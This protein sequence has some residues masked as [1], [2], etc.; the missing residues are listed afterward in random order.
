MIFGALA[1][2]VIGTDGT[3]TNM[4][5]LPPSSK[6]L[7][8]CFLKAM[9]SYS[10][11]SV[12]PTMRKDM[13]APQDLPN[14]VFKAMVL[15][16]VTYMF[17]PDICMFAFGMPPDNIFGSMPV[18]FKWIG[19]VSVACNLYISYGIYL[20]VVT[21]K[22]G[23]VVPAF[24]A[25]GMTALVPRSMLVLIS[26][27]FPFIFHGV[28]DL[29]D[30]VSA[31]ACQFNMVLWIIL[32]HWASASLSGGSIATAVKAQPVMFLWHVVAA[33][34][35]GGAMVAGV[36]GSIQTVFGSEEV[37]AKTTTTAPGE[38]GHGAGGLLLLQ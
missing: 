38:N 13:A 20:N 2:L 17:I 35:A 19:S 10:G 23:I 4:P 6:G 30:L 9:F 36:A 33:L 27:L 28:G 25:P 26:F 21:S 12:I 8:S 18:I 22:I 31:V 5:I 34:A 37:A 3:Q 16:T 11:I 14:G 24:N 7:V 29:I 15:V 32:I 1:V